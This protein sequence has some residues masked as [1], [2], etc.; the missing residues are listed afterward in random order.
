MVGIIALLL[1]AVV[2]SAIFT[3]WG[4]LAVVPLTI[5]LVA[6][7]VASRRKDGSVMTVERDA[8]EQPTGRPR[9]SSAGAQTS[10][11][12]VGQV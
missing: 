8:S 12:R 9:Q 3:I 11:E 1:V 5:A 10:N 4:L 7:F 6:S 2:I